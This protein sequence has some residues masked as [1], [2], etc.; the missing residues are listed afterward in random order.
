VVWRLSDSTHYILSSHPLLAQIE[1]PLEA[2][3]RSILSPK[4]VHLNEDRTVDLGNGEVG[5]W[6]Y[7]PDKKMIEMEFDLK[8]D[9]STYLLYQAQL[10]QGQYYKQVVKF[11]DEGKIYLV[12]GLPFKWNKKLIGTFKGSPVGLPKPSVNMKRG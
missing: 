2:P 7:K 4:L 1:K 12:K 10:K 6:N 11:G 8:N 3:I 5:I 9:D